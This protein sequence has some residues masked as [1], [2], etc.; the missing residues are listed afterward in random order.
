MKAILLKMC[1]FYDTMITREKF[2]EASSG[3]VRRGGA[4]RGASGAR[5]RLYPGRPGRRTPA[6][7]SVDLLRA[8]RE[9]RF[10]IAAPLRRPPYTPGS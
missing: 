9:G 3:D 1:S 6:F 4:G 2:S 7:L 5:R 10:T 8:E